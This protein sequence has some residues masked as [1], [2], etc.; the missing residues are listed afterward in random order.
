MIN[1][2]SAS[3]SA[4]QAESL[5]MQSSAHNT[6][7]ANTDGFQ[8]QIVTNQEAAPG[9]GVEAVVTID[10]SPGSPLVDAYGDIVGE[11]SN[12]DFADEALTRLTS[13][14]AYEANL[15]VVAAAEEMTETL[16]DELG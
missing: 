5:R 10:E 8:R 2:I 6:A 1:G 16:L 11:S 9:A 7:N 4:L 3:L 15:K 14:R 12:V 13:K